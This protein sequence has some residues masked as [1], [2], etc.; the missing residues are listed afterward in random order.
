MDSTAAPL[1]SAASRLG[2][3]SEVQPPLMETDYERL[4]P[5]LRE[6]PGSREWH[7]RCGSRPR[8]LH[9]LSVSRPQGLCTTRYAR[10]DESSQRTVIWLGASA[11]GVGARSSLH[12]VR[13]RLV[14]PSSKY[15]A[16][17]LGNPGPH[18]RAQRHFRKL[19]ATATTQLA[20]ARASEW[21]I[22]WPRRS[23][24]GR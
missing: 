21:P 17:S 8:D 15:R 23:S 18:S 5:R 3:F 10:E 4:L 16:M 2:A 20:G 1:D 11:S 13:R 6:R 22:C 14:R 9:R 12:R 24:G 7:R 19:H